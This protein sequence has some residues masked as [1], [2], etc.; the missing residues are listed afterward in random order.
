MIL[1]LKSNETYS[2]LDLSLLIEVKVLYIGRKGSGTWNDERK[3]IWKY[4]KPWKSLGKIM[5]KASGT[6]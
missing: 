5:I 6:A 3:D 2:F 1:I 4:P